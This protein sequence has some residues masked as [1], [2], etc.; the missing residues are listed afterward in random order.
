MKLT[1]Q[2]TELTMVLLAYRRTGCVIG[3]G[4]LRSV[5]SIWHLWLMVRVE[6]SSWFGGPCCSMRAFEVVLR[7]QAGPD[8]L[9]SNPAVA[10]GL[11][12]FL[13][14]VLRQVVSA[15]LGSGVR[16]DTGG[17]SAAGGRMSVLRFG[18]SLVLI[19]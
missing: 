5:E 18:P 1:M 12:K 11:W 8:R 4:L 16:A 9:F 17:G 19:G 10:K 14:R 15:V 3:I 13:M 2:N 6:V 7:W